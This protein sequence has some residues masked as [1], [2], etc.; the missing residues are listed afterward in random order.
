LEYANKV[1][2][3]Y[4]KFLQAV[5]TSQIP[6]LSICITIPRYIG[7]HNTV[8]QNIQKKVEELGFKFT[9]IAEVYQREGQQVG[10]K[11]CIILNRQ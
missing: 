9:S 7:H 4:N 6:N 2:S 3:I 1:T 10:R 8:E 5:L 11:I